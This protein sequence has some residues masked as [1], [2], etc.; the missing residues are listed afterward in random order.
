MLWGPEGVMIYNDAYSVFAG[1]RHPRLLGS[2]VREGWPE[3]ADFN[4]NVMKVGLAGGTLAYRDQELT[5]FR[6]GKPERV[7]MN[8]DY[9]P[10]PDE[11][12]RP[13]GVL[14]VVVETTERVLAQRRQAAV[15][16][17]DDAVA[18]ERDPVEIGHVAA[19]ILGEALG[20]S[21]VAYADVEADAG[22]VVV[23]RDWTAPG[24]ESM[25][26]AH[27]SAD[28]G[29]YFDD[30]RR[31]VPVRI[32]DVRRDPRTA[33]DPSRLLACGIEALM[34]VPLIEDGVTVALMA[35]HSD[36][37]RDWTDE[38]VE[39]VREL[40]ERARALIARRTAE[41][42]VRAGQ[43]ELQN[44]TDNLPLLVSFVDSD[45]RY[46]F[47]NRAYHDWF[48][49]A[50]QALVGKGLE[51]VLGP[52]AVERVMPHVRKVLA[53]E[54]VSFQQY[55]PYARG[56]G[57]HIEVE[58]V[59]RRRPGGAVDGFYAMVQ[60]I[61]ERRRAEER[62]D[63]LMRVTDALREAADTAE[64]A[65]AAAEALGRHLN[66]SRV[67]YAT[68]NAEA[69]TLTVERDWTAPG[70]P[71]I[72]GT[73]RLRDYG[74]FID[75]LKAGRLLR[76]E[77]VR[78]DPRTAHAVEDLEA[79]HCRAFINVPVTEGGELVAM[80]FVNHGD[81]RVWDD[82]DVALAEEVAARVRTAVERA[83]AV[84]ALRQSEARL[85]FLDELTTAAQ[86]AT[87]AQEILAIITRMTAR[88]MRV[89]ICAYADMDPDQDGF[90]I[91][92][93]WA[94]PGSRSIVGHYSLADFGALA[95]RELGA[96]RAVVLDDVVAQLPPEEAATFQAI[97]IGATICM[98]LVKEGRLL[99][100]MAVHHKA[101]HD[102]T[103]AELATIREVTARSWAHIERVRSE[104]ALR[105]LNATLEERVERRTAELQTAHEALRQSQKMEA[106]GQLTGGIAHDFNNL[107]AGISGSLELMGK[108][109]AEGR[110]AGLDRY[111]EAAQGAAHRAA[112]LT[113]R[114]L[115]FSRRQ[116]LD[117]RPTEMNR[118]V[119]EMEDLIRRSVGP[120]VEVEV[121]LDPDAW[122]TRVD[123]PQLEN[124]LLN[125]CINAR[126]AMAPDGGRLTVSTRNEPLEADGDCAGGDHVVLSVEDTGTGM[127]PEVIERIFDPFFT[128][129]PI[130]QG[131]G[132]GLS[133]T[134]GFLRQSGGQVR[135]RSE[136]GRG[137]TMSLCLPRWTGPMEAE[138]AE[139]AAHEAAE[140]GGR[141]VLVIDDEPTVRMLVLE[142]LRERGW[143]VLE[144]A[145]GASGL[146]LLE[147][148]GRVDLLVTDVGLPGGMNGR[149]VADAARVARPD[150]KVLFIT[151]YAENAAVRDGLAG[152]GMEVM[153]KPFVMAELA[154][155]VGDMIEE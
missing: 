52:E 32:D 124:A 137:T 50:P 132:L 55:M 45:L 62:R 68:L 116:T 139:T 152:T 75:D 95:V 118:L 125:L 100:L 123:R 97:G 12:G 70:V 85:R 54:A 81:A 88:H 20:A 117:P 53:G 86:A 112:A 27:R 61:S 37:P 141:T 77:D 113:Q 8:L 109:L 3:V 1:G 33:P 35:V 15:I 82:Q 106:V 73:L 121:R 46:R 14:A 18:D 67:G 64:M 80:L 149:Q 122:P 71:S 42:A 51:E 93:D 101:P 43:A 21:R 98:P 60:D 129:K 147:Q 36:A 92:G 91:R 110:T 72:A 6:H 49:I 134:H 155:R 153:T 138:A 111:V 78:G 108:R 136:V 2:N 5:L 66:V 145:D 105:E 79:A 31:G 146:R 30:L 99:A 11:S 76:V 148:A 74:D 127:P 150:L 24:Q 17:L 7:W 28:Y 40:G 38:E 130:G 13:A 63:V 23:P 83:R 104:A 103:P 58:Y 142:V 128:T 131:T 126:D 115:A 87:D 84:S 16:A 140:G 59:P 41:A 89:A 10:V 119:R 96:G 22:L 65:Q 133:M 29:A 135:V 144:A 48:G 26:G 107:L 154:A 69:E 143:R 19:R 4:D 57:R 44:L 39:F 94:E 114:L 90:T 56:G 9:S 34:D 120:S 151:G 47:N 25:A 102:W